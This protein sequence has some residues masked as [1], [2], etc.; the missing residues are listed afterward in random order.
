MSVERLQI[1]LTTTPTLAKVIDI[2]KEA[3]SPSR[4]RILHLATPLVL[5]CSNTIRNASDDY[6]DTVIPILWHYSTAKSAAKI[7]QEKGHVN[8]HFSDP[9]YLNDPQEYFHG[10]EKL[11]NSRNGDDALIVG[12]EPSLD[13]TQILPESN[14]L[15]A[16]LLAC[17]EA[18]DDIVHWQAYGDRGNGVAIGLNAK[19]C[20][21]GEP[22][23]AKVIYDSVEKEAFCRQCWHAVAAIREASLSIRSDASKEKCDELVARILKLACVSMKPDG[24][25][26]EKEWRLVS[27]DNE[28]ELSIDI[29]K[30]KL[31]KEWRDPHVNMNGVADFCGQPRPGD[32]AGLFFLHSVCLGPCI[33]DASAEA[34]KFLAIRGRDNVVVERS[35]HSMR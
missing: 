34:L 27:F 30:V 21:V 3:S 26:Y 14:D 31:V 25:A 13:I 5:E 22:C 17:S 8:F 10:R 19:Y 16:M 29:D 33:A 24:W 12:D 18:K 28:N 32:E 4:L 35:R 11:L 20:L 1:P 9:R 6:P 15:G 2:I 23:V 7:L